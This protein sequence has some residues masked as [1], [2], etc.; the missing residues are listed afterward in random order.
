MG[1]FE[2]WHQIYGL[3]NLNKFFAELYK[4]Y[5]KGT[6]PY[7]NLLDEILKFYMKLA[8]IY[9]EVGVKAVFLLEDCST[10]HGPMIPPEMYRKIYTTRIKK[11]VNH[12]HKLGLRVCFHTDGRMKMSRKE[13]PW[14]FMDAIVETGIDGFHG[15]QADCNNLYELKERYGDK[16]CLIGGIS[17]VEVAQYA[18][19]PREV[20]RA[21]A[22]TFKALKPGGNYIAACDNGLHWGV[23]VFN[24]RAIERAVKFYGKY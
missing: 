19:S 18:K 8:K 2:T 22:E 15:C 3:S 4:E 11:F 10:T 17:C 1:F 14:D 16:L 21:V 12:A 5:K 6:G 20:Y 7:L 24:C 13:K 9:A 23:N